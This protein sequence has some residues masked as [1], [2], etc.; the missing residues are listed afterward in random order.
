MLLATNCIALS[1]LTGL[2]FSLQR[3]LSTSRKLFSD[4]EIRRSSDEESYETLDRNMNSL[5]LTVTPKL[6]KQIVGEAV[7]Q[8]FILKQALNE[9]SLLE[10]K[11]YPLPLP[12]SLTVEQW[13]TL[14]SFTDR[15]SRFFYLDS[16]MY[17]K[18]TLQEIRDYDEKF[19]KPLQVPQEMIDQV[20]GDNPEARKRIEMFLMYHELERQAGNE[21]PPEVKAKELKEITEI[22]SRNGI[23]KYI[24]FLNRRTNDEIKD[25][26]HKS[27]SKPIRERG[28]QAKKD[29]IKE[30]DHLFYGLGNNA[31][32]L[33]L[34]DLSMKRDL[35]WR[36]WREFSLR[37]SPLIVDFSYISKLKNF[38]RVKSLIEREGNQASGSTSRMY[39][40]NFS[41]F[42]DQV[43]QRS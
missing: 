12:A 2:N 16:L 32:N 35:D 7:G 6:E 33:R 4:K 21:V 26:R 19:T 38:H 1:R 18:K 43:Q 22:H 10:R 27:H 11:R 31:I 13:K 28:I 34:S 42:R 9:I 24:Q 5:T 37:S 25:M 40:F 29:A 15:R 17:G 3:S 20:V 30:N 36:V 23:Q 41:R 39:L 8:K 14:I